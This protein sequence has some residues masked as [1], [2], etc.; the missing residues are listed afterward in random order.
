MHETRVREI[1]HEERFATREL[2]ANQ[3]R[4]DEFDRGD[5]LVALVLRLGEDA[6]Q[7]VLE[8]RAISGGTVV[9]LKLLSKA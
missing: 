2:D 9:K 8:E 5:A 6:L 4:F 3:V 1:G 7:F